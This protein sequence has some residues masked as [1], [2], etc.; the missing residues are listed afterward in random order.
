MDGRTRGSIKRMR[1]TF[2]K[3]QKERDKVKEELRDWMKAHMED[4]SKEALAQ[5]DKLLYSSYSFHEGIVLAYRKA[6]T[7]SPMDSYLLNEL[8]EHV[9]VYLTA[10]RACKKQ[11]NKLRTRI[12]AYLKEHDD[13]GELDAIIAMMPACYL[14]FNLW[15]IKYTRE[16][17]TDGRTTDG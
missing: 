8:K 3:R 14:R 15:E 6:A 13:P 7:G 5:A 2:I 17:D 9:K 10:D 11:E 12:M 1:D 16:D 4:A